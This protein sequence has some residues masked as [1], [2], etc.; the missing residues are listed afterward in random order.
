[1]KSSGADRVKS[2]KVLIGQER[3]KNGDDVVVNPFLPKGF[4]IDESSHLAF[5]RVKSTEVLIGQERVNVKLMFGFLLDHVRYRT[6][7]R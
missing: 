3:V 2:T 6:A 1:M 5:D 4:P 7:E